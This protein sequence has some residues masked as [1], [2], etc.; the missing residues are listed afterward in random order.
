MVYFLLKTTLILEALLRWIYGYVARFIT[1]LGRSTLLALS[2]YDT[3]IS[4]SNWKNS[5]MK[6]VNTEWRSV[7]Q[8]PSYKQQAVQQVQCRNP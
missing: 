3:C 1:K 5:Y 8:L 6:D 7:R 2:D 4:V